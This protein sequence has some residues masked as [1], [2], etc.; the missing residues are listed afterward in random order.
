MYQPRVLVFHSFHQRIS[1]QGKWLTILRAQWSPN[2][3]AYP[4]FTVGN[5]NH[6]LDIYSAK[7]GVQTPPKIMS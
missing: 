7:V 1:V 3:D 6:S 4:H 2:P 5:M